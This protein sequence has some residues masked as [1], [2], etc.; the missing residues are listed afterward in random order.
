MYT[1][2]QLFDY[3]FD[4]PQNTLWGKFWT[5]KKEKNVFYFYLQNE[6]ATVNNNLND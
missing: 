3:I 2:I 5:N 1:L 6:A 4:D